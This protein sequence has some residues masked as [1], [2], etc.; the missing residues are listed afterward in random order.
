MRVR[1]FALVKLDAENWMSGDVGQEFQQAVHFVAAS[2][3]V[4]ACGRPISTKFTSGSRPSVVSLTSPV[5][6]RPKIIRAAAI[7]IKS[8]VRSSLLALAKVSNVL[9]LSERW[10]L[11]VAWCTSAR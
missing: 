4:S 8:V 2:A 3:T 5:G 10:R 11:V 7:R 6:A 9:R 1:E